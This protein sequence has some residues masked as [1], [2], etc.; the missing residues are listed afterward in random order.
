MVYKDAGV[1]GYQLINAHTLIY[2][3]IKLP[4][5]QITTFPSHTTSY[6]TSQIYPQNTSIQLQWS[7][8]SSSTKE[9]TSTGSPLPLPL[10]QP[11]TSNSNNL[12][13]PPHTSLEAFHPVLPDYQS[14][15]RLVS[16]MRWR[17]RWRGKRS[18]RG[19]GR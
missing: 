3:T 10:L 11:H 15:V 17:W 16:R 13:H 9:P 5:S 2:R 7:T 6:H 8:H 14:L 18:R 1:G 4:N 12:P 19:G